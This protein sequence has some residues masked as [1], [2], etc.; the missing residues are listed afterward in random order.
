MVRKLPTF[1]KTGLKSMLKGE[2]LY[3]VLGAF[4]LL[5]IVMGVGGFGKGGVWF[6]GSSGGLDFTDYAR[7]KPSSCYDCET[8]SNGYPHLSTKSKCFNCESDIASHSGWS[9]AGAAQ[10]SKCYDCVENKQIF[11]DGLLRHKRPLIGA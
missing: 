3:Y 8:P 7:T 11:R 5:V 2:K 10:N 6:G 1:P 4:L 9:N